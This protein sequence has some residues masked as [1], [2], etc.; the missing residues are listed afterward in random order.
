MVLPLLFTLRHTVTEAPAF[1]LHLPP[2]ANPLL[3]EDYFKRPKLQC[4]TKL[5]ISFKALSFLYA[6]SLYYGANSG[7]NLAYYA[8]NA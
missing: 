1:C 3:A 5:G 4:S 7:H 8:S 2:H 6:E